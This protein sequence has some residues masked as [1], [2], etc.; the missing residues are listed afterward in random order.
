LR[1][2]G[3]R[4]RV[5]EDKAFQIPTGTIDEY[6]KH[7]RFVTNTYLLLFGSQRTPSVIQITGHM[8]M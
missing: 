2:K 4:D 7:V 5:M 6:P 3:T 1:K 8:N